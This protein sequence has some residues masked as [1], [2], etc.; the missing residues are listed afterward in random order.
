M[1]ELQFVRE[2]IHG[3]RARADDP[4]RASFARVNLVNLYQLAIGWGPMVHIKYMFCNVNFT[5]RV[6]RDQV[7]EYSGRSQAKIKPVNANLRAVTGDTAAAQA[8]QQL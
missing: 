5:S 3:E 2:R 7:T 4:A 6:A 1:D 8:V